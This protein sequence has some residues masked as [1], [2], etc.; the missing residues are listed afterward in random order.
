M[1][2]NKILTMYRLTVCTKI[3]ITIFCLFVFTSCWYEVYRSFEL[4]NQDNY[5]REKL[6]S[7]KLIDLEIRVSAHDDNKGGG[8]AIPN[9]DVSITS[10]LKEQSAFI[11]DSISVNIIFPQNEVVKADYKRTNIGIY[12]NDTVISFKDRNYNT[13]KNIPAELKSLNKVN[14]WIQCELSYWDFSRPSIP[15]TVKEITLEVFVKY[16]LN[17]ITYEKNFTV[18][19]NPKKERYLQHILMH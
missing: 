5:G 14:K 18:Y 19:L 11:F 10:S 3:L 6:I 9:I 7:N 12:R 8:G 1:N 15:N 16:S 2:K 13:F 4:P 17:N